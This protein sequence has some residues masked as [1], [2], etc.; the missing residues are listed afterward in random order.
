MKEV[1]KIVANGFGMCQV[2]RVSD[3][4]RL[5]EADKSFILRS[6]NCKDWKMLFIKHGVKFVNHDRVMVAVIGVDFVNLA[7]VNVD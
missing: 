1:Y 7:I 5:L 3:G 4:Y 2:T 6:F